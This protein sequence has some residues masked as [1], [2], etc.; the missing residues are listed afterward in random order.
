[1]NSTTNLRQTLTISAAQRNKK[2]SKIREKSNKIYTQMLRGQG[3]YWSKKR[4]FKT[5]R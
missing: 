1:M 5:F 3:K 2:L 4:S